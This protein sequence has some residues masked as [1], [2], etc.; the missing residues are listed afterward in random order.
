[1]IEHKIRVCFSSMWWCA[2]AWCGALAQVSAK[3]FD[4][5]AAVCAWSGRW[6]EMCVQLLT[7][8]R[9]FQSFKT[10]NIAIITH[11]KNPWKIRF[12]TGKIGKNTLEMHDRAK[13][14]C[15][16]PACGGVLGHGVVRLHKCVQKVL[17]RVPQCVHDIRHFRASKDTILPLL[18]MQNDMEMYLRHTMCM[19][20]RPVCGRGN[21]GIA[22]TRSCRYHSCKTAAGTLRSG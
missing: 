14:T 15:V 7:R 17:T 22:G 4:A 11:E 13:N 12:K 19:R 10:H 6:H 16:F 2:W 21:L 20:R 3:S 1:M 8:Y 18:R 5:C 9:L